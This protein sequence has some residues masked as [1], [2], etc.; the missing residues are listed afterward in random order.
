MWRRQTTPDVPHAEGR[1]A[2]FGRP[3]TAIADVSEGGYFTPI[4]GDRTED[5]HGIVPT[6]LARRV[7][8]VVGLIMLPLPGK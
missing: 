5:T 2:G 6:V 1:R 7:S 4:W 8:S 3:P